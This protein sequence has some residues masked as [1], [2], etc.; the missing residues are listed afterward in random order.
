MKSECRMA[1]SESRRPT[2]I[3]CP[4]IR[5][6]R[7]AT[8]N[9]SALWTA[10]L[11]CAWCTLGTVVAHAAETVI[12]VP[13]D[14]RW[15]YP[16]NFTAGRRALA[17]CF[18]STSDPTYSSFNDRD[19]II[20]IAWSTADDV[21]DGLPPGAYDLQSVRVTLTSPSG[22]DWPVD[23]TPDEWFN[24]DLNNDG[25]VNADGVPR[26]EPGDTDGESDDADP[27][28][29]IE[30]F[31]VGFGPVYTAA[32]WNE[33]SLYVGGD[34]LSLSPRD[35]YPFVFEFE[36]GVPVQRHVEDSVKDAFT[37]TPWGIGVP[38]GYTPGAQAD[39]FLV[40][41]DLDL[42]LSEGEV[43]HYF[44]ERL[45]AGRVFAV[46]TSL[47][48]TFKQAPSGFPTFYC[49]EGSGSGIAAPTLRLTLLPSGDVNGDGFRGLDD[50][51]AL[52][53]CLGGPDVEPD[54]VGPLT[55][56]Q[57]LFLFD[58][59]EDHDVDHEDFQEFT[60]RFDDDR[61]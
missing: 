20:L 38:E 52:V 60:L 18:G 13:T 42:G 40:N 54:P 32:N 27:G 44:Q 48:R 56:Q 35:P 25:V 15:Q 36:E 28:Q 51:S 31:G 39:P 29:P 55:V 45:S 17:S 46:I 6:S 26:G 21:P 59:D 12:D 1:N 9:S 34:D 58:F 22:A 49:K 14:D 53:D 33:F 41:F 30:L 61:S 2:A 23:L 57:C 10:R 8:L 43:R 47:R 7:F 5:N 3:R 37:P 4:F 19:G 11:V 24:F 50:L 16:F